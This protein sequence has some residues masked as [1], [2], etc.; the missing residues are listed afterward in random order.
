MGGYGVWGSGVHHGVSHHSHHHGPPQWSVSPGTHICTWCMLS[1]DLGYVYDFH[2][3]MG[4]IVGNICSFRALFNVYVLFRSCVLYNLIS[5]VAP[6]CESDPRFIFLPTDE[7]TLFRCCGQLS[8]TQ[9]RFGQII[10][11][12]AR[13]L[14]FMYV[15][16]DI[17]IALDTVQ[18]G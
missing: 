15:A 9:E 3:G 13:S 4:C 18:A 12:R 8:Q 1:L 11:R 7:I 5:L 16:L 14:C 2:R 10:P 6:R 17:S